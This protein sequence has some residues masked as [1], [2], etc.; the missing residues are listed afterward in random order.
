MR[1]EELKER[2]IEMIIKNGWIEALELE[3]GLLKAYLK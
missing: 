3:I 1:E 2:G